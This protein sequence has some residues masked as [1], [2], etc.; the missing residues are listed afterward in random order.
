[1]YT[2]VKHKDFLSFFFFLASK[3][4][5]GWKEEV[6]YSG[7]VQTYAALRVAVPCLGGLLSKQIKVS[8]DML[9]CSHKELGICPVQHGT[10]H[11]SLGYRLGLQGGMLRPYTSSG[12]SLAFLPLSTSS[13][14]EQRGT[15]GISLQTGCCCSAGRHCQASSE[16]S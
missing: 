2:R 7:H 9:V 1:M 5:G 16:Q 3:F 13:D 14:S 11:L 4:L 15:Q 8:V 6:V 12:L 10:D